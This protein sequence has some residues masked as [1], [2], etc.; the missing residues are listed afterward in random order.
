MVIFHSYVSLP[1]GMVFG[2]DEAIAGFFFWLD[3]SGGLFFFETEFCFCWDMLAGDC[4][5]PMLA[6]GIWWLLGIII[7]FCHPIDRILIRKE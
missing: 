5:G 1:E 7:G 2:G 6:G 3:I 4:L